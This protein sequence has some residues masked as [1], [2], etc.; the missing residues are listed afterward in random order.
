[1]T[2]QLR[3]EFDGTSV[4]VTGGTSGIG[5]AIA[6]AFAGSGAHVTVTGTRPDAGHYD[7]DLSSFSYRPLEVRDHGAVEALAGEFDDARRAG[8]Q[9]RRQLPRRPRRVGPRRLRRRS[10][11]QRRRCHAPDH[12]PAGGA[13]R[14]RHGGRRQRRQPRVHDGV[15]FDHHRARLRRGEGG[16]PHTDPQPGRPLGRRRHPGERGG[17]GPDRHPDD[18]ADAGLPGAAGGRAGPGH[19]A[20][21]GH[22]PPRWRRR[23]SSSRARA[24]AFITGSTLAVDGGYLAH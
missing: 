12:G 5:H 2:N 1:M 22:S 14:Q 3:F 20:A 21:H 18:R 9:R 17:P 11:P 13:G 19:P 23:C 6:S 4:L 10:R 16:P 8:Q 24:A 7:R 15:P